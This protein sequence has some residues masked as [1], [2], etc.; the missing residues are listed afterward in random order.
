MV[1][2]KFDEADLDFAQRIV[3]VFKKADDPAAEPF[4][5]KE[6]AMNVLY[7]WMKPHRA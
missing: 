5:S 6:D 4:I 2:P 7:L 3:N 1:E